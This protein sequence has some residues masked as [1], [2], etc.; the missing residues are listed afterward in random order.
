MSNSP[1]SRITLDR[2]ALSVPTLDEAWRTP[3]LCTMGN[4]V[5]VRRVGDAVFVG[6][7]KNP[8]G[9][10]LE[11]SLAEWSD[12]VRAVKAAEFDI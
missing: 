1:G 4:C 5:Q 11:C 8:H 2:D 12:F 6:D 9:P 10:R 3:S 7:T